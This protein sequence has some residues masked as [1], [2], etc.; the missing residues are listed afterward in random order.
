LGL[1]QK[2]QHLL[3]DIA[4]W[5]YQYVIDRWIWLQGISA[6]SPQQTQMTSS[7]PS[8]VISFPTNQATSWTV[9]QRSSWVRTN[10][11]FPISATSTWSVPS[12]SYRSTP[13][14]SYWSAPVALSSPQISWSTPRQVSWGGISSTVPTWR[15]SFTPVS[16][17]VGCYNQCR[18]SCGNSNVC[19][20]SCQTS[21]NIQPTCGRRS[22]VQYAGS[23][24]VCGRPGYN[25]RQN[26]GAF[27]V[28]T[29]KTAMK[30]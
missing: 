4:F 18:P 28:W 23:T 27:Y 14:R 13:S 26:M 20:P 15:K 2:T 17:Q 12:G 11:P 25:L 29:K 9:P 30:I 3:N 8:K 24:M 10:Q 1:Y 6:D 7:F 22:Q 21:C 5:L 16:G 19:Q